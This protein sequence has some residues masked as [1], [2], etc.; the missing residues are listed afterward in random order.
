MKTALVHDWLVGIGGGEKVLQSIHELF[1]SPIY[2]LLQDEKQLQKTYFEK[3]EIHTSFIQKLPFAKAKYRFYLPFFPMA[4]EQFD[5]SNFDCVIS[6][7]HA[8]AKGV[9]THGE[10]LHICYC[11][12]PM[13]YAWDLYHQYLQ[14]A[15]LS[16]GTKAAARLFL[17]YLRMWDAHSSSRVDAYVANSKFVAGRIRKIYGKQADVI[18]PP[19]DVKSFT[20]ATQKEDFYLTASRM[21]PYK[22]MDLI[23]AAFSQMPSRKLVVIGDGPDRAKV[24][25]KSAKNIEILGYQ[26]DSVLKEYLQRAKAF[27]FAAVEDFGILP[28]EAQ[29][30]GT[31]V[32]AFGR[33]AVKET[34]IE[35]ETGLF[36]SQQEIGS[37]MESVELFEKKSFDPMRIRRHAEKFSTERFKKE[38]QAF[39]DQK[40]QAFQEGL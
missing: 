36:Y 6:S 26:S 23:V 18:Y 35:G 20:L 38:F 30:C 13:R 19:V 27:V 34:I 7:S 10:Q 17:H 40:V 12:T 15:R 8:V 11:H 16:L 4:I 33:G 24:R 39:V 5:L 2:C 1:P 14:E 22:K 31:P 21:V 9:L 37:L 3:R 29:A 28:V 32:I 25:A